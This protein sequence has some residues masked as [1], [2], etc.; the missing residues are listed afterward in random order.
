M[1]RRLGAT[2]EFVYNGAEVVRLVSETLHHKH[3][4]K[5]R[6]RFIRRA[7]TGSNVLFSLRF[8]IDC[9]IEC[10]GRIAG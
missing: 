8:M 7:V 6:H 5:K 1:L 9:D 10:A 3:E 2:V 4:G